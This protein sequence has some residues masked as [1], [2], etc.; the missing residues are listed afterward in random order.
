M[1]RLFNTLKRRGYTVELELVDIPK[2]N[3]IKVYDILDDNYL[4]VEYIVHNG[5]ES[6]LFDDGDGSETLPSRKIDDIVKSINEWRI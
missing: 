2:Y 1:K 5:V 3:Y 6:T 4:Q